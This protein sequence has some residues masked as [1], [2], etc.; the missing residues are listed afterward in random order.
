M[1]NVPLKEQ[2]SLIYGDKYAYRY[3]ILTA[4]NPV[5]DDLNAQTLTLTI[6][7]NDDDTFVTIEKDVVTEGWVLDN[8]DKKIQVVVDTATYLMIPGYYTATLYWEDQVRHLVI[9]DIYVNPAPI[10]AEE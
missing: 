5:S 6:T 10:E 4:G 7:A 3:Q 8:T 2:K 1:S 9:L